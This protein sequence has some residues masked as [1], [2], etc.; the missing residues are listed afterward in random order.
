MALADRIGELGPTTP[1]AE[2]ELSTNAVFHREGEYWTVEFGRDAFRVRDSKGMRHLARLL[3]APGREIHAL[4][5]AATDDG[6]RLPV[7]PREL[8]SIGGLGDAGAILD[9]EAK[10]AYRA[11]LTEIRE[12]LNEAERWNDPERVSRLDG[13][14]RALAQELA[15]AVG[16]GGR[17]RV[18]A[19]P[20]E[21]ARGSVT[22]AI[23]PCCPVT[24]T[25]RGPRR[26]SG[27]HHPN[28]NVLFLH[29]R[30]TFAHRLEGVMASSAR[31]SARL[32]LLASPRCPRR[33]SA[34]CW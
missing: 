27:R 17:D 24:G 7:R 9:H 11:R 21:R 15:A 28:G 1:V 13:E 10:A 32:E 29:A 14:Q 19:S 18:A 31:G 34:R 25:E 8:G 3:R 22:R 33:C 26:S 2:V 23:R 6:T 20:A 30:S 12:E 4:E 16:L 5:L